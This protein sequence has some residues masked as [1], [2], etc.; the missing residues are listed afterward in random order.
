M[1]EPNGTIHHF[2]TEKSVQVSSM[3]RY[4]QTKCG[5]NPQHIDLFCNGVKLNENNINWSDVFNAEGLIHVK[6]NED[7]GCQIL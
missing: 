7:S 2:D 4:L 1:V 5:Y 6:V 3:K